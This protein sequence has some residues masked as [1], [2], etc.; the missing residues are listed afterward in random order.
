MYDLAPEVMK[1]ALNYAA[2]H[3]EEID[4]ALADYENERE[5]LHELLPNLRVIRVEDDAA[6]S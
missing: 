2:A 6:T 5:R 4:A 1:A 3:P